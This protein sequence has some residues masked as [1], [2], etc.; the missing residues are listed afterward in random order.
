V[1]WGSFLPQCKESDFQFEIKVKI[2]IGT[3]LSFPDFFACSIQKT[4]TFAVNMVEKAHISKFSYVI[5]IV[6]S[7]MFSTV[8]V[9]DG[10]LWQ[11]VVVAK[12]FWFTVIICI[13]TL[14]IPLKLSKKNEIYLTDILFGAFTI[15][16]CI[17]YLSSNGHPNM[18]WWLTLLMFPLYVAV[19]S[20]SGNEKNRRCLY[21]VVLVAVQVEAI[22][23]LLQLYGFTQ[24]HHYLYKITGTLFNPGPYSGFLAVGVPLALAIWLD[25]VI[26][27]WDRWLGLTT[28]LAAL[29]VLP[30]SMS[31]AAWIATFAGCLFVFLRKSNISNVISPFPSIK[32]Q[33]LN[34]IQRKIT[35]PLLVIAVGVLTVALLVGVYLIKKDSADGRLLVWRVS[36]EA[37]KEH[38]IFG[39][40]Y[41]RFTA[42]FGD[43]Q[44][45]YFLDSKRTETQI[46][47]ADSPEYAF[48]E[49][50]QI[51]VELGV[52]GL[53]LFL[54]TIAS[55]LVVRHFSPI[56]ASL[57]TF[58]VFA[59][60]SYPFSVLPLSIMFVF[61]LALSAPASRKISI[62]L[63]VWLKMA[64][65]AICWG[66]TT[67]GAYQILPK[68]DAYQKW[69]SLQMLYNVNSY[70][71]IV[72]EYAGLFPSL[73]HEK[74]FLFEYAQ[75][76]SKT[77]QHS[78]S[79]R[80]FEEY[81]I[82]G[83]DP[84]VFN[85]MGNNFFGM[86][87]YQQAENMYLRAS[88]IVPNRHYPLFLLM[89][90]YQKTGQ[91]EKAKAMADILLK[92]PVKV[93]SSVIR[94]IQEEARKLIIN[95]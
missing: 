75:C 14:L 85:C 46:M 41:G 29:L 60:F 7:A 18:H 70:D 37:V 49:Y 33:I 91:T 13:A 58:L 15:Y 39:A 63:P 45:T 48:N 50:V 54:L 52:V 21:I 19:R 64:S 86:G 71:N 3:I 6:L 24:S 5:L 26:P 69:A 74:P 2:Q 90:L 11:G 42:I 73:R 8:F 77:E 79:N 89:K 87:M 22:W 67:Y 31:R 59:A 66:I 28:L 65:I 95:D 94:E 32:N 51:A 82:F 92:K 68:R 72:Q 35:I 43:A 25:K 10:S 34:L 57:V 84:M 23:G 88:Q 78:E 62:K 93:P 36:M 30:A 61:L 12:Y 80:V 53:T 38:P 9:T 55:A 16:I 83:S 81:L 17:N 56:H 40:G 4:N 1:T 27:R 47:I 20:V 76:L 44:A